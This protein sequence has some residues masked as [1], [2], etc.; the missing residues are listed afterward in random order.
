MKLT[1]GSSAVRKS[2]N[3]N[4][5]LDKLITDNDTTEYN[6]NIISL[7]VIF[8]PRPYHG[9][10]LL[11]IFGNLCFNLSSIRDSIKDLLYSTVSCTENFVIACKGKQSWLCGS[12][13]RE[14]ACNTRDL[15]LIP[16]SGRFPW[17]RKWQPTPVFLLGKS[18]GWRSLA[19]YSPWGCKELDMT[20]RLFPE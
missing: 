14:S 20:E 11:H 8:L 2:M 6:R 19:G 9:L 16:G 18:H 10:Y 13:G 3:F 7:S 15:G 12:D 17:R 4:F 1:E 5:L